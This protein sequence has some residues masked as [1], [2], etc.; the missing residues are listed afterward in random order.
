MVGAGGLALTAAVAAACGGDDK[1]KGQAKSNATAPAAPSSW[2]ESAPVINVTL[3]PPYSKKYPE[4][5]KLLSD[6]HWSKVPD[7]AKPLKPQYGGVLRTFLIYT[8]L[9]DWVKQDQSAAAGR[10]AMTNSNVL[11]VE[12][13][14][15][16]RDASRTAITTRDGLAEAWEQPDSTTYVYKFRDGVKWHNKPPVNGRAFT[17]EDV[18]YA[19][20]VLGDPK[21]SVH[22][23]TMSQIDKIEVPDNKTLKMTLKQVYAPFTRLMACPNYSIFAREQWESADGL[24]KDVIGTGPFIMTKHDPNVVAVYKRNPEFYLKDEDGN[25]LPYLDAIEDVRTIAALDAWTAAY[26]SEQVDYIRPQ[27]PSQM[28]DVR[29]QKPNSITQVWPMF[30]GSI[31]GFKVN[32][33]NSPAL[34]DV[35]VRRALSLGVDR[36]NTYVDTVWQGGAAPNDY[37]PWHELELPWPEGFEQMGPWFKFDPQQA[38][39]LLAAAGFPNGIKLDCMINGNLPTPAQTGWVIAAQADLKE[40]GIDLNATPTDPVASITAYSG[41]TW[42]DLHTQGEMTRNPTEPEGWASDNYTSTSPKNYGGYKDARADAL[43]EAQRR[44]LDAKKRMT[45][46]KELRDYARDQVPLIIVGATF[47]Q[48]TWHPWLHDV[49]NGSW[50]DMTGWGCLQFNRAWFDDRAPKRQI[51]S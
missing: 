37:I 39:Q 17:A 20:T 49:S 32:Y 43:A 50:F 28:L 22:A 27:L 15:F 34:N 1:E 13:G 30:S 2:R 25:Q 44:E 18:K 41:G 29:K 23:A 3:P 21:Q 36:V 42:K 5:T 14:I 46:L 9:T 7:R 4:V 51:P 12:T 33:K 47:Q 45:I 26:L 48:P 16:A 19:W 38:R 11:N 10:A 8:S 35:R 6:Y 31:S 40:A 24:T